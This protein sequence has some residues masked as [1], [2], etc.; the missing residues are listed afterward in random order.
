MVFIRTLDELSRVVIP[1]DVRKALGLD[2]GDKIGITVEGNKI[3]VVK[4]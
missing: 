2:K 1:V 4:L 3:I